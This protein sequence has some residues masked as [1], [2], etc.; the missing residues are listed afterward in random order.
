MRFQ[1][2]LVAL[3]SSVALFACAPEPETNDV[4]VDAGPDA[5]ST[6]PDAAFDAARFDAGPPPP[7]PSEPGRHD[8]TIVSSR[9][10]V[11]SD[12]LPPE[13]IAQASNNNLDVIRF[14]GRV[15]LAFRTG[16]SHYAS[17]EV[18]LHLVS[19][20]DELTWR[21]ERTF[22]R[23]T[24]LR[25]PRFLELDGRLFL[26]LAELGTNPSDFE[27]MGTLVSER[28]ADG[29]WSDLEAVPGLE[30][31]IVWRTR[32]ERIA[33]TPTPLLVAYYGGE[34]VYD[35]L[36]DPRIRVDLLTTLDGRSVTPFD[37][38]HRTLYVGGA[39]ETDFSIGAGGELVG[40]MRNE[41]GDPVSGF[42]SRVCTAEP[43]RLA[44]W[45]CTTDPRKYD[46]PLMFFHDGEHYL[47]GR[48]NVT[49]TGHYD[50]M[51]NE[52][53][54]ALRALRNQAGYRNAPKRCA[55]WRWVAAEWRFAFVLDLPSRGDTC[56]PG[57]LA[58]A[59]P[60]EVVIY[61][62]SSDP[63]GPDIPWHVGQESPTFI[64]RHVL[65]F[66]AR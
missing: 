57:R 62:Y 66:T 30:N 29:A 42:G 15:Y 14:E 45:S 21:F 13:A 32:T 11:P 54:L 6:E 65:R 26:Y 49:W 64:Y 58:G 60:D 41:A 33:G 5:I 61:D 23:A 22:V 44:E 35:F 3:A 27:P 18:R 7:P 43:G 37:P 55:L 40:V 46:S 59:R 10:I 53:T 19:S 4:G 52:R 1:S 47:V 12:G 8:V 51:T 34:M 50:L 20:E 17:P 31:A 24:D 38:L 16:P 25:E 39:S 36:N 28:G 9:R 56:F 63:D 48:R 2:A